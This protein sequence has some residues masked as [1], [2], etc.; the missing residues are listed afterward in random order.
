LRPGVLLSALLVAAPAA[1]QDG[2][3]LILS[4]QLQSSSDPR[5]R[6]QAALVLGKITSPKA[7]PPLCGA[8]KDSEAIV[9][10]AA[11]GS[12]GELKFPEGIECLKAAAGD[13]DAVVR[14]AVARALAESQPKPPP[15]LYVAI[16]PVNDKVGSLSAD[17]LKLAESLIR[18]K[19]MSMGAT[20]VPPL[21][22]KVAAGAKNAPAGWQLRPNLGPNGDTGLK[23]EILILT[24]PDL[25][26]RCQVKVGAKGGKPE[27]Q[28]KALVP[29]AVSDGASECEW[30]Q[31]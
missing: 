16:E 22:P 26:L 23:L 10:S 25:A 13:T 17:V 6:A 11:A 18:D 15:G 31:Q 2:K 20:I 1:A 21:D 27:A 9:R 12:L 29:K 3:I 8:L 14:Q 28:L 4:K 7:V 5:T 30:K 24:Y 19:V